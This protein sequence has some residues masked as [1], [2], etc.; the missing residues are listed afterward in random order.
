ML[1]L[2]SGLRFFVSAPEVPFFGTWKRAL[3]AKILFLF[4]NFQDFEEVNLFLF[5]INDILKTV[6]FLFPIFKIF[7]TR[8]SKLIPRNF[9]GH[10][11]HQSHQG[12]QGHQVDQ[13]QPV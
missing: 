2:K 10:Q 8:P 7:E 9:Q 11:S 4:L 13:G 5:P 3:L 1:A 12:Y 6:L